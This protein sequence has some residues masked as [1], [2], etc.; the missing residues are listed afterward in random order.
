MMRY[1][2]AFSAVL[3][4]S[5]HLAA[6]TPVEEV[7][8]KYEDAS[9]AR[10]YVAKGIA[11]LVARQLIKA[12]DVAPVAS[13]VQELAVLKMA[14][15]S[16]AVRLEFVS[17]L[18]DALTQYRF[19]GRRP[20]KNGEVDVYVHFTGPETVD[21]LV[22]YNPSIYSLNSLYGDFTEKQLLALDGRQTGD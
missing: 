22:I 10:S 14:G 2:M 3:M 20:S 1:I 21:E 7:V 18:N 19:Y 5:F 13:D 4:M 17:A 16:P 15:A 11:M 8:L 9:G 12:T 6:Q